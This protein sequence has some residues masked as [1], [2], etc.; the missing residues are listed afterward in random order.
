MRLD[1]WMWS[2]GKVSPVGQGLEGSVHVAGVADVL[3]SCE[4]CGEAEHNAEIKSSHTH[5]MLIN[6]ESSQKT[7]TSI[8]K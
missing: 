2:E 8:S 4:A 6:F 7:S 5:H 3:Q 1:R